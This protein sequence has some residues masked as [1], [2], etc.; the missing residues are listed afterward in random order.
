MTKTARFP[1]ADVLA[2]VAEELVRADEMARSRGRAVMQFE[3]CEVELAVTV[4]VEAEGGFKVWVVNLSGKAKREE[5]NSLRVKM[6]AI[7]GSPIQ[8]PQVTTDISAASPVVKQR[9]ANP[10]AKK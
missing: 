3:E 1:L 2:N 10:N 7:P 5:A 4:E 6:K 9:N 8:A